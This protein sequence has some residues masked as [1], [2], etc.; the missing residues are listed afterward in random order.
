MLV[1]FLVFFCMV[2]M[3]A[4][5]FLP[6]I[7]I[8]VNDVA[9]LT[10]NGY[11]IAFGSVDKL[12]VLSLQHKL[13][14]LIMPAAGLICL[15]IFFK[16]LPSFLYVIVALAVIGGY[17]YL[18]YDNYEPLKA[19]LQA[20]SKSTG[21]I[22]DIAKLSEVDLSLKILGYSPLMQAGAVILLVILGFKD[23]VNNIDDTK[24]TPGA[25]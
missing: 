10:A 20:L 1:R 3:V 16:K 12:N 8:R 22:K 25:G 17:G 7:D 6:Y 11:D 21:L 13:I 9:V 5:F 4:G 2:A 24:P 15:F 23:P 14:M 19:T 18:I